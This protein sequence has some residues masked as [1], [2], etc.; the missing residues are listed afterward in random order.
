M[1]RMSVEDGLT[2]QL[3]A[4]SFRNHNSSVFEEFGADKGAD[5]PVA[6]EFTYNL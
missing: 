6:T 4:G 5:I 3:H 1:A 2:M